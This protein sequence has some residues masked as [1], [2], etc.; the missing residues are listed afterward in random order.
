MVD[1]LS[2]RQVKFLMW[3]VILL[4]TFMGVVSGWSKYESS[5]AISDVVCLTASLPKEYL[6][7]N[8]YVRDRQERNSE[9][10]ELRHDLKQLDTKLDEMLKLMLTDKAERAKK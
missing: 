4:I 9:L 2:E 3:L 8:Q 6:S 5:K 7:L 10:L 1:K